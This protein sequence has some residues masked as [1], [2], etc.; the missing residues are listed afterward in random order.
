MKKPIDSADGY[1]SL[2]D[3]KIVI[4]E[5]MSEVQTVSALFHEMAHSKLHNYKDSKQTEQNNEEQAA[6]EQNKEKI[7]RRTEE[8]QAE[9]I[10]FAVFAYYGIKTEENSFGYIAAWSKD[11][12]LS[13]LRSSLEV[14]NK[15][16][17]D[18]INT[19]DKNY[20]EVRKER[21][22]DPIVLDDISEKAFSQ[23]SIDVPDPTITQADMHSY[24]YTY[25]DMLP[26][27]KD[28][29]QKLYELDA[30][31]YILHYDDT[32]SMV[33]DASEFNGSNDL[34]CIEKAD[35]DR[36]KDKF[37]EQEDKS[38]DRGSLDETEKMSDNI[39]AETGRSMADIEADV[40]AGKSISLSELAGAMEKERKADKAVKSEKSSGKKPS[41]VAKLTR[42]LPPKQDKTQTKSKE[43]EM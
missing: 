7:G 31:V 1:F 41:L 27:S 30:A 35:W 20:A 11:K 36:V 28:I 19:V 8:V 26:L 4:R 33:L 14:I 2:D 10:S 15:T 9:S 6:D 43:R 22:L 17:N 24:G 42:P 21:G 16:A 32:E 18:M 38:E 40:K 3:Q 37:H 23:T 34:Y 12:D 39:S 13:E 25:D 29:A 5:G